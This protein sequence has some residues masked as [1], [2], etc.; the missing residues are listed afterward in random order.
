MGWCCTAPIPNGGESEVEAMKLLGRHVG[1][2]ALVRVWVPL[3]GVTLIVGLTAGPAGADHTLASFSPNNVPV[4]C[5]VTVTGTNFNTVSAVTI[6]GITAVFTTDSTTQISAVVPSGAA[7][8]AT[9]AVTETSPTT[10]T[11]TLT[12]FSAVSTACPTT[13]TSFTPTSGVVGTSVVITGTGFTGATAVKFNQTSAPGFVVNSA[14]QITATV[15]T[16]ATTGPIRVTVGG[17]TARSTANFTVNPV[18]APTIT[19]F[20]PLFGPVGTSVTITG[21]NF[22]GTVS[23]TSFTTSSVKFNNVAATTFHVD[24][25]TQITATVPTG[26]T[27]GK[28]T[29]TTPGGTATSPA[30][31][32]VSA[33]HSRSITLNLRKHLVARGKVSVGDGFTACAASVPVKIQ[34]R[35]SG[36]WKNVGSTTTTST[37]SYKKRIKDKP[38]KYR[39]R[40]TKVSINSGADVCSRATS[41]VRRHT[42]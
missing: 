27:T 30:N 13:V 29:V 7:G 23:G 10:H 6:D 8:A 20:T 9:I 19:S 34:R 12:G 33:V 15:P 35:V 18:P 36:H 24:S 32:T 22:S 2:R 39:A 1:K 40:A 3:V 21:T 11:E 4:G 5:E 16:G 25:P 31:F 42:H 26:A 37:G 41:P 38:G 17:Q 14:T 28:I